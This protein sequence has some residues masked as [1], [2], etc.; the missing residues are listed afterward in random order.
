MLQLAGIQRL[1]AAAALALLDPTT[2]QIWQGNARAPGQ[3]F[4]CY[5]FYLLQSH[6][7]TTA[8]PLDPGLLLQAVLPTTHHLLGTHALS[9]TSHAAIPIPQLLLDPP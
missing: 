3:L 9:P 4:L 5:S 7:Y 8:A 1:I 6:N 2:A